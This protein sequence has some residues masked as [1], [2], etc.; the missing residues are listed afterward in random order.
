ME[1]R[2][3][4]S[5]PDQ[6]ELKPRYNLAP[7]QGAAVITA[8]NHARRLEFCLWGLVP[9]W[10]KDPRMG[11]KMINAR[12]ETL[13]EKP[14]F[15]NPLRYRRCLVPANGFYEWYKAPGIEKKVPMYFTVAQQPLFAFA[16]LWEIWNDRDGGELYSFTLITRA[17]NPFMQRYHH[18]MP[19][20]LREDQE[21]D[22]L[23]HARY[24]P[25]QLDGLLN[26]GADIPLKG[27][28]VSTRVNHVSHDD[29][30]CIKPA[31]TQIDLL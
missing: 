31:D 15:K 2:F 29:P 19:L 9:P 21:A 1:Q 26:G 27:Y 20:I 22:W 5:V 14:S 28:P 17:A 3:Q 12:A 23:D 6:A 4:V 10:A 30:D 11:A 16:G 7:G 13:W 18:R 24:R 25:D 8:G